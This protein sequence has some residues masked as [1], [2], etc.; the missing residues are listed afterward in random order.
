MRNRR[1]LLHVCC[2]PDATVPWPALRGEGY[3]TAAF[4]YGS[5]IHPREEWVARSDAVRR[6][7]GY[8]GGSAEFAEYDPESWF[9]AMKGMEDEPEGGKRCAVCFGLQLAAAARYAA[10]EGFEYL[11]T[12]LSISP[13]KSPPLINGVGASVSAAAGLKWI[14][15]V[16]RKNDGFRLSVARSREM[17]LYRQNYCGCVYSMRRQEAAGSIFIL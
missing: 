7:A 13:H 15:R 4:F 8:V 16:W 12:T 1:A 6:L 10:S 3:D 5:G 2:A 11:C 17:G 9:A 14:E